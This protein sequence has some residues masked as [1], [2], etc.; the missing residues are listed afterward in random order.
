MPIIPKPVQSSRAK[1]G[2]FVVTSKTRL[3]AHDTRVGQQFADWLVSQGGPRL[4]VEDYEGTASKKG[5]IVIAHL[6]IVYIREQ[7]PTHWL[8]IRSDRMLL[9]GDSEEGLF[10]G[11]QS[12]KQLLGKKSGKW[13]APSGDV[14]DYAAFKWRGMHLDVSRHFF[15][16][17]FVEQYIDWIA[18]H[19]MNTFHW[20]LVDDGGWRMESKKY[21][22]LTS[23]G[24]WRAG[25]GKGWNQASLRFPQPQEKISVYG[26]FYSQTQIQDI[27]QYA[28]EQFVNIVPEIEMP[29]HCLPALSAYPELG[30]RVPNRPVNNVLCPANPKALEYA[31]AILDETME[32]FPSQYIHIGADEV[33]RAN[34]KLCPDCQALMNKEGLTDDAE[35]QSWFVRQMD[36]YIRSKGRTLVGWDEILEGGLAEGATVMSWRGIAGGIEAAKQGK[37]VVMS[38]TSHCYFDFP[39]ATTSTEHVYSFNPIPT[40][41]NAQQGQLVLGGQANVWT[42]WIENTDRVEYM[43]FPRMAALAETLWIPRKSQNWADFRT[44]LLPYIKRLNA[45]GIDY[46]PLAPNFTDRAVIF[47]RSSE[48]KVPVEKDSPWP[49]RYTLDGT[50]P[51]LKSP[52]YTKPI[53]VTKSVA[54]KFAYVNPQGVAG[55]T[56]TISAG[57]YSPK[58]TLPSEPGL[59]RRTVLLGTAATV[60]WKSGFDRVSQ[61]RVS[62]FDLP[63]E[64]QG[65]PSFACIFDGWIEIQTAGQYEFEL[66]SDDGSWLSIGGA[67][68]IDNGGLHGYATKEGSVML[69][70]G[71]YPIQ[72]RFHE[73]G[74][75]ERLTLR[76]NPP[77][78]RGGDGGAMPSRFMAIGA[79]VLRVEKGYR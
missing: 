24:A 18:E 38:P 62:G 2:D 29:G 1:S 36:A 33:N 42:E 30:C 68:V 50:V 3:L 4:K 65:D 51:T 34:W 57:M 10:N 56:V 41:L 72:V 31:K 53:P 74:G 11:L 6:P 35:L 22:K 25:N 37:H 20:H 12:V 32:L 39:Y 46:H 59:W 9:T 76:W 66:G 44:R 70:K 75:A 54:A 73:A 23:I 49:L 28:K 7:A 21:P 19:K 45:K 77:I 58:A 52:V 48:I 14:T 26:G 61:V 5:A 43:I 17:K 71:F 64:S 78:G 69:E 60:D 13:A 67:L 8:K 55:N 27:V 47:D 40:E 79:G 16:G 63:A 15:D